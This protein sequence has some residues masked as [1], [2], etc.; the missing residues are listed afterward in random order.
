MVADASTLQ[1]IEAFGIF[2]QGVLVITGYPG[3][4]FFAGNGEEFLFG[5]LQFG[6]SG[7]W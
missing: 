5:G 6:C 3:Q 7:C 2:S 4:E 1:V